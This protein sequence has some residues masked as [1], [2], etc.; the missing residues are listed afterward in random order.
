MN[1]TVLN[2][3]Y[4]EPLVLAMGGLVV[5]LLFGFFAQRSRFCLRAVVIEFWHHQF[6]EKLSVWLL[7]FASAVI[8][9]Q[10]LIV[11][12]DL[13]VS[14]TRQVDAGRAV[15]HHPH[16]PACLDVDGWHWRRPERGLSLLVFLPCV[17]SFV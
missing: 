9:I 15:F 13:D 5:G 8:A 12:G 3:T 11:L 14:T 7:T 2:E 10:A 17:P 6:G 16:Q 1:L 4:G